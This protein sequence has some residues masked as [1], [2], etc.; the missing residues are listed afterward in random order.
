MTNKILEV[1]KSFKF[2][3]CAKIWYESSRLGTTNHGR[4]PNA[5]LVCFRSVEPWVSGSLLQGQCG[6]SSSLSIP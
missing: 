5:R 6:H 1:S 3:F 4:T 2:L